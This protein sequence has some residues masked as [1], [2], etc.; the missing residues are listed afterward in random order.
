M[1]HCLLLLWSNRIFLGSLVYKAAHLDACSFA[2]TQL[3]NSQRNDMLNH[4]IKK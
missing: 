1:T 4:M 3:P 2:V